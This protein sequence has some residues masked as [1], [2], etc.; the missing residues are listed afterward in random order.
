[1]KYFHWLT[2]SCRQTCRSRSGVS[3]ARY[4]P[5]K[6][7]DDKGIVSGG[8]APKRGVGYLQ[9][10][11]STDDRNVTDLDLHG[12]VHKGMREVYKVGTH[13]LHEVQ[14]PKRY[15]RNHT[16][17]IPHKQASPEAQPVHLNPSGH[18]K[19]EP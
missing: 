1:M 3:H 16:I 11:S 10:R 2:C 6:R 5:N 7:D 13:I 8:V 19:I 14:H 9:S 18:L 17:P 4:T 15:S 12:C